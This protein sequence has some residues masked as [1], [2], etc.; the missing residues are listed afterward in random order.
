MTPVTHTFSAQR[1]A[2][3]ARSHWR[4]QLRHYLSWLLVCT[5]IAVPVLALHLIDM[6]RGEMIHFTSATQEGLYFTGLLLFGPVFAAQHFGPMR[7][8][9]HALQV[10]MQPASVTEKWSLAALT[11]LLVFPLVYTVWFAILAGPVGALSFWWDSQVYQ[12]LLSSNPTPSANITS[13]EAAFYELYL[14]FR[15]AHDRRPEALLFLCHAALAGLAVTGSLLFRRAPF[16]STLVAG[17]LVALGAM[18][19]ALLAPPG[20]DLARVLLRWWAF[21]DTDPAT[22]GVHVLNAWLWL[23]VPCLLWATAWRGLKERE[24]T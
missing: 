24:L 10:L 9:E 14:P 21:T 1:F 7:R 19:A 15:S 8:R 17:F 18:F 4:S 6:A 11:V 13:P 16:L 22:M 20:S 3:L 5:I 12:Q 23:V 2:L